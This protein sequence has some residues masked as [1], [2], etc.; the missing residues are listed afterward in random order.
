MTIEELLTAMESAEVAYAAAAQAYR[1]GIDSPNKAELKA[2][3]LA[4]GEICRANR[5][6][7]RFAMADSREFVKIEEAL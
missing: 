6:A 4:L 1:D 2:A 5:Q 3:A 7:Y